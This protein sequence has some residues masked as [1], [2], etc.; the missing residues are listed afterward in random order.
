MTSETERAAKDGCICRTIVEADRLVVCVLGRHDPAL[1][2]RSACGV[3]WF[4]PI[5]GQQTSTRA[6]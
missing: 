4:D 2:H 5:P 6:R 3:E 1:P